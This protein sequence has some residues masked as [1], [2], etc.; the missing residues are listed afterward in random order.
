MKKLLRWFKINVL[1]KERLNFVVYF[2]HLGIQEKDK[3]V[4]IDEQAR[5]KQDAKK[6]ALDFINKHA[7]QPHLYKF[8]KVKEK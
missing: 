8:I 4:Y 3:F 7:I 2:K 5:S 1:K 6:Q